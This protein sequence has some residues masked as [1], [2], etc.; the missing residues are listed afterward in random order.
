MEEYEVVQEELYLQ[1]N[2]TDREIAR[3][4]VHKL[5]EGPEKEDLLTDEN[6]SPPPQAL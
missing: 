6:I 3:I 4:E 1:E 5:R 2:L